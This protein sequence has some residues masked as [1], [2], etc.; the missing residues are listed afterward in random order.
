MSQQPMNLRRAARVVRRYKL[1]VCG[2]VV[3][4]LALGA[5]YA[6]LHPAKMSS[7]ALVIIPV[8]KPN[9]ATDTLIGHSLPVLSGALPA[10]GDGMTV[11]ELNT[12]VTVQQ[13][14]PSVV[15]FTAQATTGG[16]AAQIANAVANSYVNY[17][18]S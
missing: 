6:E 15:S 18:S 5:G 1:L 16:Q 7:S 4:G 14:T 3:V 9:I 12:E 10:I 13:A 8:P 17:L 11:E 2:S